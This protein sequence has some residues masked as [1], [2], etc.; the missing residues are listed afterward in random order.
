MKILFILITL[1]VVISN[2]Q[3]QNAGKKVTI[4]GHVVDA[5]N[6]PVEGASILLDNV[7]SGK[8]T[9]NE[10]SYK[11]KVSPTADSLSAF[12]D[13]EV[14][15]SAIKNNTTIDFFLSKA[16]EPII[17]AASGI[18]GTNPNRI[19]GSVI[20]N[21]QYSNIYQMLSSTVPGV[22]VNGKTITIRGQTT[23]FDNPPPI[24][25][26]NGLIIN[27]IDHINPVDV[28]SIEVL[29][30]SSAAIYGSRG[31]YGVIKIKT[32]NSR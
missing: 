14:I 17:K 6:N 16:Q 2:T 31:S 32:V 4:S 28:V 26:V 5:N 7:D 29:K 25:D 21:A 27:S 24:F 9:N 19:E 8:K 20:K 11:I 1:I 23:F 18:S 10:G 15:T 12:T 3:G 30:A 22:N 13:L